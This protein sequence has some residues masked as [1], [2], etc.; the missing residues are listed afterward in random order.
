MR[1]SVV[2]TLYQS[3][4][5]L[6]EFVARASAAAQSLVGDDYELIMVNDGS[7]DRSLAMAIEWC[8]RDSHIVVV[9]LSRNFGHHKA[10]MTGLA[11]AHGDLLFLI[12]SDLEEDPELLASFADQMDRDKCEVVYGVQSSRRGGWLERFSGWTYYRAYLLLTRMP[13]AENMSTVRLMSR[14]YVEALVGH[15]E[16]EAV[17]SGL[18]AM[19]GFDQRPQAFVKHET[20]ASTYSLRRKLSVLANTVTAFSSAPL[21]GIFYAGIIVSMLALVYVLVLIAIWVLGSPAPGWTSV[22]A[23]VWLLGGMMISFMGVIGIYLSKIFI[24]VKQ[25]PY[26]IVRQV[27]GRST[28]PPAN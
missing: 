10:I 19:T 3:A 12:D 4:P 7:P 14:R 15:G 22:M 16:R 27:H 11:H 6:D 1:L 28:D 20:S 9:D 2:T 25:R 23:S 8:E 24:E 18:W 21:R 17:I 5:H 26:T 13:V